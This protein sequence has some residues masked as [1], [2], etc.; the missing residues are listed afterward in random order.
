MTEI[1]WARQCAVDRRGCFGLSRQGSCRA[2]RR[3]SA[4]CARNTDRGAV[5]GR[6]GRPLYCG[7]RGIV[8]RQRG[9]VRR[10]RRSREIAEIERQ[11]YP[12]ESDGQLRAQVAGGVFLIAIADVRSAGIEY[13]RRALPVGGETREHAVA[14]VTIALVEPL[15]MLVDLDFEVGQ[16]QCVYLVVDG[17]HDV[18]RDDLRDVGMRPVERG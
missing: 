9:A 16:R 17:Q 5:I 7:L 2:A 13:I 15:A 4:G 14:R 18:E 1:E 8:Q 11:G 12:I 6:V 10:I 3:W